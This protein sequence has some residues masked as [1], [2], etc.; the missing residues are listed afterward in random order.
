MDFTS[1]YSINHGAKTDFSSETAEFSSKSVSDSRNHPEAWSRLFRFP[2]LKSKQDDLMSGCIIIS[3][4]ILDILFKR[5]V[6]ILEKIKAI[7]ISP[8]EQLQGE[9]SY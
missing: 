1:K 3:E 8:G 7:L 9:G 5:R 6:D 2:C 4:W